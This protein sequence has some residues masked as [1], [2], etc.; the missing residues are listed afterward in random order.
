M[1]SDSC[2]RFGS[3]SLRALP[4]LAAGCLSVMLEGAAVRAQTPK[5]ASRPQLEAAEAAHQI[6]WLPIQGDLHLFSGAGGNVVVQLGSQ[7]VLIVDAGT[8]LS[9][10]NL[11]A[12]INKIAGTR[13]IRYLIDTGPDADH[14]G[15]NETL[16]K[17]GQT[18][19]GG[20]VVMDDPRG[21]QGASVIAH[22]NV[23]LNMVARTK[24][25]ADSQAEWPS[26]TFVG[27]AYD[28]FFDDE[29]VQL[30]HVPAAHT[31]G[32]VMVFF[33]KSDV[34]VTGDVFV[35]T[36]Y[37]VI[38]VDKGG[39]IDGLID[40]LNHVIDITVP[41]D[42][43]EGGTIVVPGHGRLCDEADVVEYRDMVTIIRDRIRDMRIKGSTLEQV[44]AAKP[45]QDYDERFGSV[46]GPWTT[47]Q[48]VEAVYRTLK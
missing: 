41:R 23:Q 4:V 16:R 32:D 48:F 30:I 12:G 17:A 47:A 18:I 34:L 43:E 5:P 26:E 15:G 8:R 35:T 29:A 24:G 2:A 14:V 27:A 13:V 19:I 20:N 38:E 28:L 21:Q 37:P 10:A 40:A 36:S 9:A 45:T 3:T 6:R 39:T 44:Q 11:A 31:N 7:G 46:S 42:K 1:C 33:R 22:E 25:E